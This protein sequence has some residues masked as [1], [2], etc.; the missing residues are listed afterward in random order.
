MPHSIQIH[1]VSKK[2]LLVDGQQVYSINVEKELD[3]C[4]VYFLTLQGEVVYVGQSVNII[5]RIRTHCAEAKTYIVPHCK[6]F[7]AAYFIEVPKNQLNEVEQHYIK[8][9]A[10]VFNQPL[11]VK[12]QFFKDKLPHLKRVEDNQSVMR[13]AN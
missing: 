10:P 9:H 8:V 6:V 1:P 5:A 7:D 11:K 4:G 13:K 3:F 12:E 2:D